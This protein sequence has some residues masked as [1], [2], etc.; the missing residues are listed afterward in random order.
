MRTQLATNIYFECHFCISICFAAVS[1]DYQLLNAQNWMI[2]SR[3]DRSIYTEKLVAELWFMNAVHA[4]SNYL[5][6]I[7]DPF[8]VVWS[9][10]VRQGDFFA[11]THAYG[12]HTPH[13]PAVASIG[14]RASAHS[15][16]CCNVSCIFQLQWR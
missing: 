8:L 6:E 1:S 5:H 9:I 15:S 12:I 2:F 13:R 16:R 10:Y 11:H 4:Y 7:A 14:M 3:C